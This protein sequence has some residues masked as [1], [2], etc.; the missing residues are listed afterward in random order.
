MQIIITHGTLAQ[1]R[2]LNLTRSKLVVAGLF[3]A[4]LLMLLSGVIYHFVFLTTAQKGWPLVS[5]FSRLVVKDDL[6]QRE[7]YLRENLDAMAQKLGEMQA[8]VLKLEAM[9]ER[10]APLAGMKAE[11]FKSLFKLEGAARGAGPGPGW[12]LLARLER[13]R[14]QCVGGLAA[15]RE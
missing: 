10:V 11:E 13:H 7:R 1:T 6:A 2:V 14:A 3:L 15:Q 8:K 9:G 4:L 12:P 5:S